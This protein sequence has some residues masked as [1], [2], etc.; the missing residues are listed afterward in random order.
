MSNCP[1]KD[2]AI[3]FRCGQNHP[4]DPDCQN[5]MC[6]AN[7]AEMYLADNP[8]CR[9]KIDE[10][11]KCKLYSGI[12]T[13][14]KSNTIVNVRNVW[15]ISSYYPQVTI[16]QPSSKMAVPAPSEEEHNDFKDNVIH[17]NQQLKSCQE[18]ISSLTMFIS[19]PICPLIVK[20]AEGIIRV[21][22]KTST[23]GHFVH[24]WSTST[25][26]YMR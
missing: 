16:C 25:K 12:S 19:E 20:A 5:K 7:C 15:S 24:W 13:S 11:Y 6:C 18:T 4:Y 17:V 23:R 26:V 22:S 1:H 14:V 9:V 3:C 21:K 10:H 2:K 8:S